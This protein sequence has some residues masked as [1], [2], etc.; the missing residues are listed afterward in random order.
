MAVPWR[1]GSPGPC[2]AVILP[3]G[4]LVV[5]QFSQAV[6]CP[7]NFLISPLERRVA[8]VHQLVR[9]NFPRSSLG[10]SAA[11]CLPQPGGA[12]LPSGLLLLTLPSLSD[13]PVAVGVGKTCHFWLQ[14]L[15]EE[16]T[17]WASMVTPAHTSSHCK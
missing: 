7:T 4:G 8:S 16:R 9:L 10:I 13:Q 1:G 12:G 3:S 6:C 15:S 11:L 2:V 14:V 17:P 5:P